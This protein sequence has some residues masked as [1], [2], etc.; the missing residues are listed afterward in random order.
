MENLKSFCWRVWPALVTFLL[1]I[2]FTLVVMQITVRHMLPEASQWI[3]IAADNITAAEYDRF[4]RDIEAQL[5]YGVIK[6]IRPVGGRCR[7]GA[8]RL[9]AGASVG[10]V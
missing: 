10:A 6:R 2:F 3:K 7:G 1:P 9:R 8:R 5:L 4:T